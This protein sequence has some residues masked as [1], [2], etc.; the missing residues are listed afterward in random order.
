MNNAEIT[1]NNSDEIDEL[2]FSI[3]DS[4]EFK[5]IQF[6]IITIRRQYLKV[7]STLRTSGFKVPHFLIPL[8]CFVDKAIEERGI[9]LEE[10]LKYM[11][12]IELQNDFSKGWVH[13]FYTCFITPQCDGSTSIQCSR[14]TF[15]HIFTGFVLDFFKST[16]SL[17]INELVCQEDHIYP[18]NQY[19]LSVVDGVEFKTDYFIFDGK[20]YLYNLLT[21]TKQLKFEDGMPGFAR[22]ITDQVKNGDILLRLDENL[23][24]PKDQAISY[25]SAD[26]E[27]F[28]GPQF[29]FQNSVLTDTKTIIVHISP[30]SSNKLLMVIKKDYDFKTNKAFLHIEIETLPYVKNSRSSPVITTFLHGM[31]YLDDD[32]FTHIDYTKNQYSVEEYLIKYSDSVPN[33][34]IDLYTE[35]KELHYKIWCIEN[36]TYSR[37]IW[38]QLMIASLPE[39]Y[40]TLLN[41]ILE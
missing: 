16:Y 4:T 39:E 36:G 38:Y 1:V 17:D 13:Y 19:G 27:K 32:C 26:F 23:A 3:M 24:L 8:T 5:S 22:I 35:R 21:N 9:D 7:L 31:Y 12:L 28:R 15:I 2:L 11:L 29:H 41:E 34:P 40:Q 6:L 20:A 10:I 14:E 37:E 25:S 33:K 18:T 30:D